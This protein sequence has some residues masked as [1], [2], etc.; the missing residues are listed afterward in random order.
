MLHIGCDC[1]TL[2]PADPAARARATTWL[3]GAAQ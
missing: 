3:I 1:E 2:L